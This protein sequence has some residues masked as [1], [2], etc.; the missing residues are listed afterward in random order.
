LSTIKGELILLV[1]DEPDIIQLAQ[2][3]LKMEGFRIH[4]HVQP[5]RH[6]LTIIET[7]RS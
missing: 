2:L 1:D 5:I 6:R 3:Y 4:L 7:C